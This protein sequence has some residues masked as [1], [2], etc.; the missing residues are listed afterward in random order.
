MRMPI[1]RLNAEV[2]IVPL[3]AEIT[4][5]DVV[6]FQT[7]IT[8]RVADMEARGVVV[9][10]SALDLVDSYMARVLNDTASMMHLLGADVVICGMRPAVALTL[11]EMGRNMVGVATAFNLEMALKRLAELMAETQRGGLT[12]LSRGD[13]GRT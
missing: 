2:L 5:E 13:R 11:V 8:N 6:A 9:D 10:I 1:L 7:D 12:R 3:H 4:D